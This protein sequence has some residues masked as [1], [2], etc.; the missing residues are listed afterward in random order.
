VIHKERREPQ[1]HKNIYGDTQEKKDYTRRASKAEIRKEKNMFHTE[2]LKST[3]LYT[4]IHKEYCKT[5][6]TFFG[7]MRYT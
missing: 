7:T 3:K 5:C 6:R 4:E 2:S 1:E